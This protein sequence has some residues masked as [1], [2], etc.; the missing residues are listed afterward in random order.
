MRTKLENRRMSETFS[1]DVLTPAGGVVTY[2]V[3]LGAYTD[4]ALGEIFL[5]AGKAGSDVDIV[6]RELALA[7]SFALQH[8]ASLDEMRAAC[9]RRADGTP[10]GIA[11][12]LMDYLSAE[13]TGFAAKLYAAA[14]NMRG[15]PSEGSPAE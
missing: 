14:K 15:A 5:D 1:L 8:G 2:A 10:E 12:V 13:P 4:G 6:T 7:L 11:G 3:T 9:P